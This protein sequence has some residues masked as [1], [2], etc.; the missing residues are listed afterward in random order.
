MACLSDR[1]RRVALLAS[2]SSFEASR[3][4]TS[5]KDGLWGLGNQ[6][7]GRLVPSAGV[8]VRNCMS[9]F[10]IKLLESNGLRPAPLI[11]LSIFR[12]GIQVGGVKD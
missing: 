12:N 8:G 4:G 6:S 3:P 7:L 10:A 1:H 11:P 9:S 5:L 2:N